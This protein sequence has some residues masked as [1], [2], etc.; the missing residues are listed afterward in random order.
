MLG[1]IACREL[2]DDACG[3]RRV[4]QRLPA[5]VIITELRSFGSCRGCFGVEA[6]VGTIVS[7]GEPQSH[8]SLD[9]EALLVESDTTPPQIDIPTDS[10]ALILYTSGTT[11]RPRGRC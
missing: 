6:I 3:G 1:A 10:P 2:P 11:G 5:E 4:D 9:Y 8:T 7:G